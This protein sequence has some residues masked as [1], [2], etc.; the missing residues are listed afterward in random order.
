MS[1]S[2]HIN[3]NSLPCAHKIC[4]PEEELETTE[5]GLLSSIPRSA[6][7]SLGNCH[8]PRFPQLYGRDGKSLLPSGRRALNSLGSELLRSF[9]PCS[10]PW[11]ADASRAPARVTSLLVQ[12]S[13][14]PRERKVSRNSHSQDA[15]CK[16]HG[17]SENRRQP[18]SQVPSPARERTSQRLAGVFAPV[19]VRWYTLRGC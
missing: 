10:L 18:G 12:D 13:V 2:S 19:C 9:V 14:C 4:L 8:V 16:P 11:R 6:T 15:S 1:A 17:R 5:T 3:Q 7:G